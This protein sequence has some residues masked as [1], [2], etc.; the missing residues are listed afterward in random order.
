MNDGTPIDRELETYLAENLDTASEV[1]PQGE[2]GKSV[3][4]GKRGDVS[5]VVAIGRLLGRM[6][7]SFSTTLFR[8]IDRSGMTDA[9]V[10][11]RALIDRRLFSKI[12][13]KNYTPSKPTVLALAVAL[14]LTL[15]ET[16]DLLAC[17]GYTLSRNS[18]FDVIVEYYIV[19]GKYNIYRINELLF[20][21]DQP[22]LG[23]RSQ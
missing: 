6:D 18:T 12:R 14:E 21:H 1:A 5:S 13:K 15:D 19:N 16:E 4:I 7:E 17:A 11:K 10:Y 20:E 2:T 9:D 8:L 3:I 22:L 23:G